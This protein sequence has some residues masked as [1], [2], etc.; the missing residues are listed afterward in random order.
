MRK[1][2][3]A[4]GI[5]LTLAL[6]L[7]LGGL[8][9]SGWLTALAVEAAGAVTLFA[10]CQAN[11]AQLEDRIQA[12]RE[13]EDGL[14]ATMAELLAGRVSL[15]QAARHYR[16]YARQ[17]LGGVPPWVAEFPGSSDGERFCRAV[18]E[19]GLKDGVDP[20]LLTPGF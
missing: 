17:T 3:A 12:L 11:A 14:H 6:F 5:T 16:A 20:L 10:D 15:R 2:R 13:R 1:L 19:R 4:L 7:V 9:C 8:V 18:C